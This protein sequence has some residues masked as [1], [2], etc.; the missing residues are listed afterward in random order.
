[1][2]RQDKA[3]I[4]AP[5]KKRTGPPIYRVCAMLD[6]SSMYIGSSSMERTVVRN[7]APLAPSTIR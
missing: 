3:R 4:K 5:S 2:Y 6:Q 7:S 1:M